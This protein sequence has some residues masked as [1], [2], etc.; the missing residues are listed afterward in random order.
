MAF[1]MI[2]HCKFSLSLPMKE[3]YNQSTF[4]EVTGKKADCLVLCTPGH[5]PAERG[6]T[7]QRSGV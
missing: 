5:S 7:R 4:G 3:F 6:R 2:I 1:S